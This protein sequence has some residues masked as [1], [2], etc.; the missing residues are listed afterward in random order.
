MDVVEYKLTGVI[1]LNDECFS[2]SSGVVV[3]VRFPDNLYN[4]VDARNPIQCDIA[5]TYVSCNAD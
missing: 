4:L 2:A 3:S 5:N 1:Y